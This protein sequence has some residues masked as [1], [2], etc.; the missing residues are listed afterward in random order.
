MQAAG[1]KGSADEDADD[2]EDG[3]GPVNQTEE[4]REQA[5]QGKALR[6]QERLSK[7][8][9]AARCLHTDRPGTLRA[10][11]SGHARLAC[12]LACMPSSMEPSLIVVTLTGTPCSALRCGAA[13]AYRDGCTEKGVLWMGGCCKTFKQLSCW[14]A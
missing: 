10:Q 7:R 11:P 12:G 4:R 5:L 1:A 9:C 8:V 3:A 14:A 13:G 2:D 6:A